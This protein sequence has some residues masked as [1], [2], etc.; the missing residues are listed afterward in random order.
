MR[1]ERLELL[2]FGPFT[3]VVLDLSAG[4]E[5][6][7]LVYGPNEAGKSSALR[8]L[9]ALLFGFEQR[10]RDGFRHPNPELR[11]GATLCNG[12]GQ[13]LTVV[14]RKGRANTLRGADD[15]TV[16]AE[17]EL[18]GYL[19]GMSREVFGNLFGID[20]GQLIA[21][22]KAITEGSGELGQILFAA[23]TGI[24]DLRGIQGELDEEADALFLARGKNQTINKHLRELKSIKDEIKARRLSSSEWESRF[25]EHARARKDVARV[26]GELADLQHEKTRLTRIG[27]TRPLLA[28]RAT[29]REKLSERNAIPILHAGF[30]TERL[31][32][33]TERENALRLAHTQ[34]ERCKRFEQE[35]AVIEQPSAFL[36][37]TDAFEKLGKQLLGSHGKARIDRLGLVR[38]RKQLETSATRILAELRPDLTIDRADALR[39]PRKQTV[40]L[41]NLGNTYKGLVSNREH[42]EQAAAEK[43]KELTRDQEQLASPSAAPIEPAVDRR[44]WPGA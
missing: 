38:E 31:A 9:A 33:S 32:A 43:H 21:G 12:A 24:T 15:S 35:L 13:P 17:S 8:A 36:D 23:G 37:E 11:I 26:K 25:T 6:L 18:A 42:A 7:H 20:H 40:I 10:S 30:T 14:R 39:F 19:G 44:R 16:V 41:Q 3:D 5:G 22:G 2:A 29:L 34:A 1:I 27:N 4:S 28:Q